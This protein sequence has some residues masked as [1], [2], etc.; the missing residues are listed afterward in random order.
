MEYANAHD[1][2]M[3]MACT[4]CSVLFIMQS[5][6]MGLLEHIGAA[7]KHNPAVTSQPISASVHANDVLRTVRLLGGVARMSSNPT[8]KVPCS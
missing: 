6:P 8:E 1:R 3:Q 7:H 5:A 4:H 2:H